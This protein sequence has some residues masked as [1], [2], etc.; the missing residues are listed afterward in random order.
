MVPLSKGPFFLGLFLSD[1]WPVS[2]H[3]FFL[4]PRPLKLPN[5]K[6]T[7]ATGVV[8][9]VEGG[10]LWSG[11]EFLWPFIRFFPFPK[12][13]CIFFHSFRVGCGGYRVGLG[14][15]A[16]VLQD[17][18]IETRVKRNCAHDTRFF[19]YYYLFFLYFF[20]NGNS[21]VWVMTAAYVGWV[22]RPCT[23]DDDIFPPR[24]GGETIVSVSLSLPSPSKTMTNSS[25]WLAIVLNLVFSFLVFYAAR[26][27]FSSE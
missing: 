20:S 6:H 9:C 22:W 1:Q 13:T 14:A 12:Y 27:S 2:L 16:D 5:T 21:H 26:E 8:F 19:H 24:G 11:T 18:L 23:R 10:G 7:H 25:R 17:D 15:T 3:S 4:F